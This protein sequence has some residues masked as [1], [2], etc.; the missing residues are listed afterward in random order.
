MISEL[1]P[2]AWLEKIDVQSAFRLLKVREEDFQL[3]G[4]RLLDKFDVDKVLSLGSSISCRL[5][6][7]VSSFLEWLVRKLDSVD[8]YLGDFL[9]AVVNCTS[10]CAILM[11]SFAQICEDLGVPI[12]SSKTVGPTQVL[13]YLGLDTDTLEMY[14]KVPFVKLQALRD[15]LLSFLGRKKI[16]LKELQSLSGSLNF[17]ARAIPAAVAFS[18][19]FY[20]ASIGMVN[21]NHHL[22]LSSAMKEDMHMWLMF[23][24]C[25]NGSVFFSREGVVRLQSASVVH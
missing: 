12:A 10:D 15:L 8:H 2:A 17:C 9:F 5:L 25:F 23:L 19:R 1:G 21:L 24:E 7:I 22:R 11:W 3:L 13:V 18:R 6:E 14:V 20:D 4:F 16:T